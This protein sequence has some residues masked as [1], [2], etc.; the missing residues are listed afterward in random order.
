MSRDSRFRPRYDTTEWHALTHGMPVVP[1]GLVFLISLF[2]CSQIFNAIVFPQIQQKPGIIIEEAGALPLYPYGTEISRNTSSGEGS[3]GAYVEILYHVSTACTEAQDYYAT[4]L[5]AVNW[6][7]VDRSDI[8][9]ISRDYVLRFYEKTVDN[10][11]VEMYV[12]CYESN[13]QYVTHIE[14][15]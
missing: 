11:Q 2:A 13:A 6:A 15:V 1:I 4:A 10:R 12:G 8:R 7:A 9:S 3:H 14:A 5:P